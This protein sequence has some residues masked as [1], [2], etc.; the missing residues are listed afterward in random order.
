MKTLI[1]TLLFIGCKEKPVVLP[2]DYTGRFCAYG[3][4]YSMGENG[5]TQV[6]KADRSPQ[7]CKP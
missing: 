3:L 7:R 2:I 4:L 6:L 5:M 1:L